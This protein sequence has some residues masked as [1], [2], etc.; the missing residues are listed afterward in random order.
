MKINCWDYIDCGRELSGAQVQD[1][2]VCRV[3]RYKA[4]HRVNGG[5]MGGR[6]CWQI[7]GTFPEGKI[8]CSHALE[9]GDCTLCEFFK[10][11]KK[12]EGADFVL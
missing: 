8:R 5:Y 4:Y 12:E 1:L 9:L 3:L 2:G 6:S 10:L 11:V 7:V